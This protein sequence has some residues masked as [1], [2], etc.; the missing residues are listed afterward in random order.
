MALTTTPLPY[1]LRDVK[2]RVFSD[3]AW[4][5]PGSAVDL[6]NAQTLSFT[7]GEEFQELRGDDTVITSRGSGAA[8]EWE[9]E[10]G[11]ISLEAYKVMAGG[12]IVESGTTP[13]QKKAYTKKTT[14]ARPM[15]KAE[16]QS[17]SDSGGDFHALLYRCRATGDLEGELADGEF[18]VTSAS[19]SCFGSAEATHVDKIYDLVQNETA[20]ALT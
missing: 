5:T 19:G 2:V 1:G 17:M 12:A 14:D 7:E 20:V 13:A 9:L 8:V 4:T 15:F 16:G 10:S 6:P 11:G 3:A 18:W